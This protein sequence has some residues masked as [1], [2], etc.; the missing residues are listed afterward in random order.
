MSAHEP[1]RR[2]LIAAAGLVAGAASATAARA[3]PQSTDTM[4]DQDLARYVGFGGKASG[5][6]GDKAAG[7]WMER[8]LTAAGFRCDRLSFEAPY[9]EPEMAELRSGEATAAVIPQA[10]VVP[11]GPDGIAGKMTRVAPGIAFDKPL[12]GTIALVD[13]PYARWSSALAKPVRGT[14]DAALKAGAAACVVITNGPT[15]KAIALNADGRAPMFDR[16]VAILAPEDAA[17]FLAAAEQ[18]NDARLVVHGREGRRSA[19][20]LVGRLD[21]RRGRWVVVSTPRSGWFTCAGERGGGVAAWL[22]LA[23]WVPTALPGHD[24]AFVC[25]SGHEYENLGAEHTL[26]SGLPGPGQTDLWLHLGANVAARD[27]HELGGKMRPLPGADAQ[28]VLAVSGNLLTRTQAL[29]SGQPGLE[30]P[31]DASGFT[32]GE[33]SNVIAAGYEQ[34]LG[35]FGAHRYH[36]VREDNESCLN[37]EA[38]SQVIASLQALLSD[39]SKR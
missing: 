27:W 19:F 31:Y 26:D 9:F 36:H 3:A 28:R 4:S 32:A 15:G 37:P 8:E 14:I 39:F 7:E 16:P 25:N 33:L 21:R 18:A 22:A 29:F 10:I 23:R 35:I 11:T 6:P 38:T 17:P 13:L 30:A 20:N 1:T 2:Q 34:V 24:L 5:G 12:H